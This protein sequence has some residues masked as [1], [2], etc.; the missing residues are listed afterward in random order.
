MFA[1]NLVTSVNK[2]KHASKEHARPL[3][4]ITIPNVR[5]NWMRINATWSRIFANVEVEMRIV[6]QIV[7][8][9]FLMIV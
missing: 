2:E 5:E 1:V 6:R 9:A 4:V 8:F 7:H 3:A